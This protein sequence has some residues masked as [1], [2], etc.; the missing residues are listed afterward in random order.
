MVQCCVYG[1]S[2]R[3]D[4]GSGKSFFKVP[5][6]IKHHG[7]ESLVLSTERRNKWFASINRKE[8]N[9]SVSRDHKVCEDH[10]IGKSPAKLFDKT[11]PDWI[12]TVN[13]GYQNK[14]S[15]NIMARYNRSKDRGKDAPVVRV[16][17]CSVVV[18][19][20]EKSSNVS[21]SSPSSFNID[22]EIEEAAKKISSISIS[23]ATQT[24]LTASTVGAMEE[25]LLRL[26]V[27]M[28]GLKKE[29]S[30]HKIGSLEWFINDQKVKF[31][32]GLPNSKVLSALFNYVEEELSGKTILSKF[33][34]LSFTLMRIRLNL[35][36]IDLSYRFNI[37]NSTSSSMFLKMLNIL[38]C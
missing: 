18:P 23:A 37:S 3:S 38:F 20:P 6:I 26:N 11:N 14:V 4:K 2:N 21:V 34:Q 35:S 32:T 1:C 5:S 22:F 24:E 10:F 16:E 33:E 9:V 30:L 19:M 7:N 36:L 25:E 12:P 8:L 28:L 13:M 15:T 29:I 17:S 27:T 31:Y